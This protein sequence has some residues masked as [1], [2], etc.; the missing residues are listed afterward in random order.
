MS[1]NIYFL[2]GFMAAG[3]ST[4]APILANTLGW[5]YFDLD[6]EIEKKAGRKIVET[7]TLIEISKSNNLIIS[8]GGGT[9]LNSENVDFI[10]STGKLIYLK[11]SVASIFRRL[12]N[13][14]DRPALF[15]DGEF[16]EEDLLY[17]KIEQMLN[18]RKSIYEKPDITIDTDKTSVGKSVDILAKIITKNVTVAK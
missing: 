17:Q 11:S 4:I 6:R 10:K 13:K 14:R 7:E 16:P 1:K 15:I 12:K 5:Q 2:T 3:K 8:L 9:L 18:D